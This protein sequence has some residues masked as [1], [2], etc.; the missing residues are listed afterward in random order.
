MEIN[1]VFAA[2]VFN[3]RDA[4]IAAE[5]VNV[6]GGAIGL[7]HHSGRPARAHPDG[8]IDELERRDR[9]TALGDHVHR[10]W[11]GG[12]D[13]HRA[14]LRILGAGEGVGVPFAFLR[15]LSLQNATCWNVFVGRVELR[16]G[17]IA[18]VDPYE[19]LARM[20]GWVTNAE[21]AGED[22]DGGVAPRVRGNLR[23]ASLHWCWYRR[24]I[25]RARCRS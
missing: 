6:N 4:A 16:I 5:K 9:R 24:H 8:E 25:R 10:R 1:E 3:V 11:S 18:R 15:V 12:R 13:D 2:V 20:V 23:H 22:A 21:A 14:S 7:G 19:A 17:S